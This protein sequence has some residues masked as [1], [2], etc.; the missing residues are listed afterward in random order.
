MEAIR[1][2]SGE[3]PKVRYKNIDKKHNVWQC[4]HCDYIQR[5]EADGPYEN[6]WNVCPSCG[7]LLMAPKLQEATT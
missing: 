6:G 2:Q 5:F 4:R 1:K 7:G 3:Y